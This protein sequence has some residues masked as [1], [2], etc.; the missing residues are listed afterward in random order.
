MKLDSARVDDRRWLDQ[1]YVVFA[2][3]R[4]IPERAVYMAVTHCATRWVPIITAG[5]FIL[6][7]LLAVASSWSR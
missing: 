7:Y 6:A 5:E 2:R 4:G 3:A 1:D